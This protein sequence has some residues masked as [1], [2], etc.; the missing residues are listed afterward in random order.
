[1]KEKR[2]L[3]IVLNNYFGISI[4][5]PTLNKVDFIL[6]SWKIDDGQHQRLASGSF[7]RTIKIW[8]LIESVCLF[9]LKTDFD[10]VSCLDQSDNDYL[11]SGSWCEAI[12]I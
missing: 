6:R 5:I 1:M 12:M 3:Q 8:N 2:N 4:K 10:T 9:P 7:D 11:A